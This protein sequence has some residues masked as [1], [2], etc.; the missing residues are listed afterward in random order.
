MTA[1]PL[2]R[3]VKSRTVQANAIA[4]R[5]TG[6]RYLAG[7]AAMTRWSCQLRS[8][9]ATEILAI[10]ITPDVRSL[11]GRFFR[12]SI[13]VPRGI[14]DPLFIGISADAAAI[15]AAI[16]HHPHLQQSL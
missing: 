2:L 6:A 12:R 11:S 8:L 4:I 9:A 13:H 15:N 7:L 10:A 1:P 16:S 14:F 5:G 3:S